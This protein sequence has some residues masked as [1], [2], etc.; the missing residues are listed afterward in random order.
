MQVYDIFFREEEQKSGGRVGCG[1]DED[2]DYDLVGDALDLA[3]GL[4]GDE[5]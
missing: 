4:S 1:R 3:P 2:I 5:S